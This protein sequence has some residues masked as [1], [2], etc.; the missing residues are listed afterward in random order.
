M[1]R[2][3]ELSF[4]IN[5]INHLGVKLYSTIPPMLAELVSNAWD[6]DA[7]N[8]WI[9]VSNEDKKIEVTDDGVGMSFDELNDKFLKVG[10][11]RR[12]ELNEDT[13]ADGRKVLGKKGLGKLSMFGI[14]PSITVSSVKDNM[15]TSFKMDYD[16]IS[17]EPNYKPEDRTEEPIE[18]A[19]QELQF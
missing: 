7:H 16:L 6:A 3:L 19:I 1:A 9:R 15:I 17:T 10:R 2:E 18:N 13:T 11:N 14:G 4:D 12:I 8:V 5:T